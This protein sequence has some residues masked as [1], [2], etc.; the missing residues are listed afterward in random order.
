MV[1]GQRGYHDIG[2]ACSGSGVVVQQSNRP[3]GWA[4][5]TDALRVALGNKYRL[6]EQRRKI[7]ELGGEVYARVSYYEIRVLAMLEI[8]IEKGYLTKEQVHRRMIMIKN[9]GRK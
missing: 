4:H 1:Y 8:S 9:E 2:G 5:L 6:H 7:E 3:P